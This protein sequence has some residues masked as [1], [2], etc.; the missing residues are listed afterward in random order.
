L[1]NSSQGRR[2]FHN[3]TFT[4]HLFYG[5]NRELSVYYRFVRYWK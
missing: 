3:Q 5:S 4:P 2:I 1:K